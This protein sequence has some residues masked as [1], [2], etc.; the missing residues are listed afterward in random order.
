MNRAGVWWT[1]PFLSAREPQHG[2]LTY[3]DVST[4]SSLPIFVI[5]VSP[6]L[7]V[8]MSSS[9]NLPLVAWMPFLNFHLRTW[10]Q[11]LATNGSKSRRQT[12]HDTFPRPFHCW[13]ELSS[14]PPPIL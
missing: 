11:A 3:Q 8:Q 4:S 7:L 9:Q 5:C 1:L 2:A 14:P 10:S 13:K 12:L 6:L